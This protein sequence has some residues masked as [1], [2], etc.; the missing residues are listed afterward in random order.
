[1][2]AKSTTKTRAES[3]DQAGLATSPPRRE[4]D[5]RYEENEE[6]VLG[7]VT[8]EGRQRGRDRD[9]GERNPDGLAQAKTGKNRSVQQRSPRGGPGASIWE[10]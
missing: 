3:G 6:G 7:E 8:C 9:Q 2:K 4:R 5:R 1:V 10:T